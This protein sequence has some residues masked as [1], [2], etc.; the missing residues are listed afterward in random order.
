[1]WVHPGGT[2]ETIG[3][4]SLAARLLVNRLRARCG[5]RVWSLRCGRRPALPREMTRRHARWRK[6]R[7]GCCLWRVGLIPE[8]GFGGMKLPVL[9]GGN[10]FCMPVDR[11]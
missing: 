1:M 4:K 2:V 7:A 8:P 3:G 11:I 6:G 9:L 5:S 10:G